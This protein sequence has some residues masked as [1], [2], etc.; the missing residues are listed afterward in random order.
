[1]VSLIVDIIDDPW[2]NSLRVEKPGQLFPNLHLSMV[3]GKD[4]DKQRDFDK[5][6][7]QIVCCTE[8]PSFPP[9]ALTLRDKCNTCPEG[10]IQ[11]RGKSYRF[12]HER[13]SWQKSR[14]Y[15]SSQGSRLLRIE[16]KEEL[17]FIKSH[18]SFHWIGLSRTAI[19]H[20]WVWQDGTIPLCIALCRGSQ[21]FFDKVQISWSKSR[22]QRNIFDTA[23]TIMIMSK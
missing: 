8:R 13:S 23:V 7:R 9:T 14:E 5:C 19:G 6:N 21:L 12:T 11:H 15:C 1:M 17:G 20:G 18:V 3:Q 4:T 16:N 2:L 10:W 22:L